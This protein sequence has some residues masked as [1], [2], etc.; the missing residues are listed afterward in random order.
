MSLENDSLEITYL[1]KRYKISLN[2]T[3]SDEMKHALKERFHNQE[4]NA[5]ELLK[6][7]LHESCQNEYLHNEL[8]KLLEKISSCSIT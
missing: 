3:F 5:L 6:D 2:N 1:G 7:Y 8:Q 4:L